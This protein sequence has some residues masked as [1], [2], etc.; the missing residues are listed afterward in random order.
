M[1]WLTD[2][3]TGLTD[4]PD[5]RT[6]ASARPS[7]PRSAHEPVRRHQREEHAEQAFLATVKLKADGTRATFSRDDHDAMRLLGRA[8]WIPGMP[9]AEH[10]IEFLAVVDGHPALAAL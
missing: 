8:D 9:R 3:L 6:A 10:R 2:V 4:S 1:R 7:V 5:W